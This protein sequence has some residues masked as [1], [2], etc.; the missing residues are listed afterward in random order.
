M[1]PVEWRASENSDRIVWQFSDTQ[2]FV[3][4]HLPLALVLL[5]CLLG[6]D[7]RLGERTVDVALGL[8]PVDLLHLLLIEEWRTTLHSLRRRHLD[9]Y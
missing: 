6:V 7:R 9:I 5:G 2:Y 4:F 3:L 1:A 8:V